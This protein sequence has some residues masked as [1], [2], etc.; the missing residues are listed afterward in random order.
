MTGCGQIGAWV[1]VGPC[2]PPV[3]K[4]GLWTDRAVSR[5]PGEHTPSLSHLSTLCPAL[6]DVTPVVGVPSALVV[7]KA[8]LHLN[9]VGVGGE[10]T[11]GL[12]TVGRMVLLF[13]P[14]L[15]KELGTLVGECGESTKL[16]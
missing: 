9:T 5:W 6:T 16:R 15:G 4:P 11:A 12:V 2:Q 1:G 14:V 7:R 10:C 13:T 8:Q 3:C